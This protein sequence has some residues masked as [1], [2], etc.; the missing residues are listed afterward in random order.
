MHKTLVSL[1]IGI[2][3]FGL[4]GP[5]GL[6]GPA[7]YALV[8]GKSMQPNLESGDLAILRRDAGYALRDIVAFRIPEGPLVIHRVIGGSGE[9]GYIMQGDNKIAPDEWRPTAD[10]VLGRM[11]LRIPGAGRVITQ[12]RSPSLLAALTAGMAMVVMGGKPEKSTRAVR[13][14][15]RRPRAR[16]TPRPGP[17]PAYDQLFGLLAVFV[18]CALLLGTLALY[19]QRQPLQ[20]VEAVETTRYT[21]NG[22]FDYRVT[23]APSDLYAGTR[24]GPADLTSPASPEG[25]GPMVFATLARSLELS[26]AYS[27]D[28][29]P[30]DA[31]SGDTGGELLLRGDPGWSRTLSTL[32]QEAF[33]G[34]TA[35]VTAR[36][37][38]GTVAALAASIGE[39]TG[40]APRTYQIAF[41]PQ[42]TIQ[43][44][45][46]GAALSDV[47]QPEFVIQVAADQIRLEPLLERAEPRMETVEQS[48]PNTLPSVAG[49]TI[50]V[51]RARALGLRGA[52]ISG[53]AAALL[54]A[55][56]G[57][58]LL[59]SPTAR[60]AARY[61]SLLVPVEPVGVEG[62]RLIRVQRIS[63]LAR[64][65]KLYGQPIL[66]DE[67]ETEHHYLVADGANLYQ[68]ILPIA[69]K[70]A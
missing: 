64:V 66:H 18:L 61:G 29:V 37:D 34:N 31:V 14:R 22:S 70:V 48:V 68:Y 19:S 40:Y 63:D 50:S 54:G 5:V 33:Q 1:A 65:A 51:A 32:P 58:V 13:R 30:A 6:G 36:V 3:W 4:L 27:L 26:F 67:D 41:V 59:K 69:R 38:F 24:L 55:W 39:Q 7:T 60:I 45:S 35:R 52:L 28:G 23:V 10:E 12:V 47:Y 56:L 25:Q 44:E 49:R 17:G 21:Q 53:L 43:G 2:L 20:R 8:T 15:L 62:A 11:W 9:Q 16:H 46:G 57:L 42:V